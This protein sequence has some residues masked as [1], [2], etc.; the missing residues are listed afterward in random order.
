MRHLLAEHYLLY[1]VYPM[2][3]RLPPD[4]GGEREG[5]IKKLPFFVDNAGNIGYTRTVLRGG[6]LAAVGGSPPF[7]VPRITNLPLWRSKEVFYTL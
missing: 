4:G 7:T 6:G 3:F 1:P 5:G 2:N